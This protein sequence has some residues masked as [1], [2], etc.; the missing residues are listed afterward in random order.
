MTDPNSSH[1]RDLVDVKL[2]SATAPLVS[3]IMPCFNAEKSLL[4]S[5]SS[6]QQQ[7]YQ[8][9]EL[10]VV[11]DGSTDRSLEILESF[12]EQEPR[13][14]V[15][16]QANNGAAAARNL[17]L[18]NSIGEYIAFLDADDTWH[19]EFVSTMSEA[20]MSNS[21]AGISYCGWQNVGLSGGRG[22]PY[23]PPDYETADK[24]E[25]L[26]TVCPWPIHAVLVRA[27]ILRLSGG[28]DSKQEVSEDYDLW[29]RIAME[30]KLVRV[31]QVLAYY[32]FH[33]A[34]QVTDNR[35]RIA[36]N[37]LRAQKKFLKANPEI[38]SNLGKR[39]VRELTYG[40]MLKMGFASYWARD[41]P[42]AREIFIA[43]I[44]SGYG[45]PKDWKYMLPSLLP[46][47]FHRALVGL[48]ERKH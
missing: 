33:D 30:N 28:F 6:V 48:L 38:A 15:C 26:L 43:V 41:L 32:H 23:I 31:P 14:R 44:K 9:W 1:A 37:H 24:A 18:K 29:L 42:A 12:A 35:A 39:R 36:F 7:S 34:P 20:L 21:D 4:R 3:V 45:K 2:R 47:R 13:I 8:N 27:R 16:Q 22:L 5:V 11:D 19:E 17:G 46:L 25:Q 10:V 40:E